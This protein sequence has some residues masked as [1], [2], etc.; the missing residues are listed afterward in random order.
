M[1]EGNGAKPAGGQG[2]TPEDTAGQT[3][4]A[5]T[6]PHQQDDQDDTNTDDDEELDDADDGNRGERRQRKRAQLAERRVAELEALLDS[7]R[8]QIIGDVVER[9]GFKPRLLA[10]AGV[11]TEDL[12]GDDGMPDAEKIKAAIATAADELG[13]TPRRRLEPNPQ[14]G[15]KSGQPRG[16]SSWSRALKG[17]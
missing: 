13:A 3:D 6:P 8:Q 10:A 5:E 2:E 17:V 16:E 12:L 15:L 9:Q 4:P 14:M 1:T 11:G 7:T